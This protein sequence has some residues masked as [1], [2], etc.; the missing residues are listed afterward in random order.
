MRRMELAAAIQAVMEVIPGDSAEWRTLN[1]LLENVQAEPTAPEGGRRLLVSGLLSF[2][3]GDNPPAWVE[4]ARKRWGMWCDEHPLEAASVE[5]PHV[6]FPG[7][8]RMAARELMF[9]SL[10]NAGM[11]VYRY[12]VAEKYQCA[13][14]IPQQGEVAESENQIRVWEGM[15]ELLSEAL[16]HTS[17]NIARLHQQQTQKGS[18]S[19]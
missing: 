15:H 2:A 14:V 6:I 10:E 8:S 12:L 7:S 13:F 11:L 1:S 18:E 9:R 3:G 16:Q 4:E 5:Q 19:N 17:D